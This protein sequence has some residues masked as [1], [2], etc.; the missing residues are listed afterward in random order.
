MTK[1]VAEYCEKYSALDKILLDNPL[2]LD[3]AHGDFARRLSESDDGRESRYTSEEL[4]RAVVVLFLEQDAYRDV[5][6]R[7]ETSEFLRSFMGFGFYKPM[8]DFTLVSKAFSA[9][10]AETWKTMNDVLG[11]YALAGEK[12]TGERMRIDTTVY[13]A[14]I[15]YPTDSS[16]LWDGYRVLARLLQ[17][18]QRECR[19]LGLNH[20]YHTK[21]VKKLAQSIARNGGSK[22]KSKQKAVKRWY[23]TL[24]DRVRWIVKIAKNVKAVSASTLVDLL[25]LEHFAALAGRVIDQA[26]RRVFQGEKVPA[27]EKLYSLFEEHVELL[28]RGKAGK[29]VEF[30]HLVVLAQTGEKFI[31]HYRSL[32]KRE[33]D[34]ALLPESLDAHRK[35]FG[36]DPSVLAADKGFYSGAKQLAGLGDTIETVSIC[37]KGMRT[38]EQSAREHTREFQDGQRFRSGIE[39]SISVLKRA[40]KLHRCFFKGIKNFAASVGCAVFC[41]NLVLLTRL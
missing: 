29:P 7:I 38:P 28:I 26:E 12:I 39:G 30:G 35:L 40:F 8:M 27:D 31:T 11:Q 41:H 32:P 24:I 6:V 13:E 19:A 37:K 23:R 10:S 34:P 5:V 22:S 15:H 16:L 33:E 9:L 3:L 20:R 2:V 21:K 4:L 1:V 25:T 14:N 18:L 17:A 36:D